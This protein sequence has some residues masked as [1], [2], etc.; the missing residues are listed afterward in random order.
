M[1]PQLFM[2]SWQHLYLHLLLRNS[3]CS[4]N[5]HEIWNQCDK[6]T[7]SQKKRNLKQV[8]PVWK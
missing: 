7:A 3:C 2:E 1:L 8:V 6:L 4:A 5:K